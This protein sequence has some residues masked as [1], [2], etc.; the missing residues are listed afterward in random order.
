[1]IPVACALLLAVAALAWAAHRWEVLTDRIAHL[2]SLA[3]DY[4]AQLARGDRTADRLH[5]RLRMAGLQVAVER[6]RARVAEAHAE[7]WKAIAKVQFERLCTEKERR[8]LDAA[9]GDVDAQ[10][11]ELEAG[12]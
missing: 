10:L 12:S 4:R 11:Q 9:M 1:M 7:Q 2:N 6:R 8:E 5:R 3:E